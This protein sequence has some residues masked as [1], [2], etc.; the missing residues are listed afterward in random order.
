MKQYFLQRE[1]TKRGVYLT[2]LDKV[3]NPVYTVSGREFWL[4]DLSLQDTNLP[5]YCKIP[6]IWDCVTPFIRR[7]DL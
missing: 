3:R 4:D 6:H 7:T 1:R 2:F 5:E